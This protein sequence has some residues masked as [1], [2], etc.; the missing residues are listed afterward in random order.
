MYALRMFNKE[1]EEISNVGF[2][3]DKCDAFYWLRSIRE[4]VKVREVFF[5][6]GKVYLPGEEVKC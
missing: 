4:Y 6:V 1:M 2:Y 3:N 5:W